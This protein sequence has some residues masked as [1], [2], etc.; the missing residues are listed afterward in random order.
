M[1]S[2]NFTRKT[3]LSAR[4]DYIDKWR[5]VSPKSSQ[6]DIDKLK[7]EAFKHGGS[8]TIINKPHER[9][10]LAARNKISK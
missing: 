4:V 9:R 5:V 10:V 1:H 8:V 7:E 6:R 2:F 3:S